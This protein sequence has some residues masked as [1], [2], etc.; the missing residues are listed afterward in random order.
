MRPPHLPILLACWVAC[1]CTDTP[2]ESGGDGDDC[3]CGDPDGDGTDT[4][5]IPDLWGDW[6]TNFGS[7]E[8]IETCGIEDLSPA[9]E[10]WIN[11]AAMQIGG[12][13]PDG[14]YAFFGDDDEE[15]FYGVVSSHG[16]VGFSGRHMRR[17]G[18]EAHVAFGGLAYHDVYRERD[19][20][21]GFGFMGIDLNADGAIECEARG[22]FTARKS[23][24]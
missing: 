13:V 21:E 22:E 7:Q 1:A 6:T 17:D 2:T 18:Y 5:D 4:G 14:L 16:S 3:H 20:I 15:R 11:N 10:T 19:V 23:G 24:S 8:F 9:S 12:Y